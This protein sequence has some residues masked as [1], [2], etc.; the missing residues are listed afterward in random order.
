M[1]S[2]LSL[3]TC[4]PAL[5]TVSARDLLDRSSALTTSCS[6]SLVLATTRLWDTTQRTLSSKTVLDVTRT[7]A[8]GYDC[9]EG[10]PLTDSPDGT[11]SGMGT[12]L[13]TRTR[14]EYPNRT[15]NTVFPSSKVFDSVVVP[16][17]ATTSVHQLVENTYDIRCRTLKLT[18]HT[19]GDL[20]HLVSATLSGVTTCL[21][22]PNQLDSDWRK[23]SLNMVPFHRLH[24]IAPVF[25]PITS[26]GYQQY[27]PLPVSELTQQMFDAK[28]MMAACDP[29]HGHSFTAATKYLGRMPMEEVEEPMLNF[30]NMNSSHFVEWIPSTVK[31]AVCDNPSRGLKVAEA[32]ANMKDLVSEYQQYLD[33]TA[34]GEEEEEKSG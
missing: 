16:H 30:Q 18:T 22:F 3:L 12:R 8:E 20:N 25:C 32:E 23:L 28:N 2:V 13:M 10:F 34:E 26:R 14:E 6:D 17:N 33:S 15:R 7:E 21:R 19:H 5:W 24:F 9:H 27:Y 31:T 29:R 11:D 4:S 1:C